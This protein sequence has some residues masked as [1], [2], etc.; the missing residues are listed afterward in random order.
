MGSKGKAVETGDGGRRCFD[1]TV[2]AGRLDR[3]LAPN[4]QARHST[5][6]PYPS[7]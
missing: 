7:Q 1:P 3:N 5:T 4:L 6:V 2:I